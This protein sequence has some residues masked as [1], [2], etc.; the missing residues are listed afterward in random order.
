MGLGSS[1]AQKKWKT[2]NIIKYLHKLKQTFLQMGWCILCFHGIQE[3]VEQFV[4]IEL[5]N[6]LKL[7]SITIKV[8]TLL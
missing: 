6:E 4:T 3:M 8:N 2:R 7:E 1:M 5:Y